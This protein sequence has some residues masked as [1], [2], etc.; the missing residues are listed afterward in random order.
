MGWLR[1]V[2]SKKIIGLFCKIPL[3]KRL[4][5]AKETYTLKEPPTHSHPM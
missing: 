3:E 4:Y 1:L 5:S 2:G